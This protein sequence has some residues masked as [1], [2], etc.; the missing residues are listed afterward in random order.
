MVGIVC[1]CRAAARKRERW[2]IRS[3]SA[4]KPEE[5]RERTGEPHAVSEKSD[6]RV[7]SAHGSVNLAADVGVVALRRF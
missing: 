6:I 1:S 2:A 3:F 4:P 7:I 5:Q